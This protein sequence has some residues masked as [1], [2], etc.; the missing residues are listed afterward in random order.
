MPQ[1]AAA[2]GKAEIYGAIRPG[3]RL[4]RRQREYLRTGLGLIEAQSWYANR[5]AHYAAVFGRLALCMDWGDGT[6]RP[7]H[8][9]LR[10]PHRGGCQGTRE[11]CEGCCGCAGRL[12]S[13]T[14][15]RVVAWCQSAGLLGLVSPG[16][17]A[18]CR[19][20]VLH[21]GEGNLAAIYV[22]TVPRERSWMPSRCGA[23]QREFADLSRF[24]FFV[25]G[26]SL[27]AREKPQ[28]KN[29]KARPAGGQPML[30]RGDSASLA[31]CPKTGS[32]AMAAARAIQDHSR[33]LAQLSDRHVRHLAQPWFAAGRTPDDFLHALSHLPDGPRHIHTDAVR[34]PAGWARSR[35]ACWLAPDGT[36]RPTP[37][38]LA[39]EA[40]RARR[41]EQDAR[42]RG[43]QAV[44]QAAVDLAAGLADAA[45]ASL[46][47]A[48]P[49]AAAA[50]ARARLG[51]ATADRQAARRQAAPV[52]GAAGAP[53][54]GPASG[55]EFF[56]LVRQHLRDPAERQAIIAAWHSQARDAAAPGP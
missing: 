23:G 49:A 36:L 16:V 51:K 47:A 35:L 39:A 34:D 25:I 10:G 33:E 45:R 50:L 52:G 37:S 19:P 32:E 48:S 6:A 55:L 11:H 12:S 28:V 44:Q 5:K 27:R 1:R 42:R 8:D 15:A 53:A 14:V 24:C 2:P 7:G 20:G 21:G 9:L 26:R 13:D 54:P 18:D 41:A 56:R 46:A 4:C 30:P 38:Q 17:T 43:R 22:C 31:T 40:D 3:T 29:R